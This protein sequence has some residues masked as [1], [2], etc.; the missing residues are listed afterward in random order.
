MN[1]NIHIYDTPE[2]LAEAFSQHLVNLAGQLDTF[3]I[4]LSGG[5]T[6]VYLFD[7]LVAHPE[8]ISWNK[9]KIFWVDERCVP[10]T[11]QE[12]NYRLASER[13]ISRLNIPEENIYRIHGE[14]DPYNEAIRYERLI[15]ETVP[16]V[17]QVPQ[18]DLI[19]LG[20][21]ADGHTASIFPE[22]IDLIESDRLC[23][24]AQH[25]VSRQLRVTFTMKLINHARHV[26]FLVTGEDKA[27]KVE[28]VLNQ[29][30]EAEFYPAN[31]VAPQSGS[32]HWFLDK[33]AAVE[34]KPKANIATIL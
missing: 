3:Y 5:K 29:K 13:L 25:P 31:F 22:Q 26:A 8:N 33:T 32:L 1:P 14:A 19:V 24:I 17:R 10:P 18:F 15:K 9:V 16:S 7:Y 23:T 20:M 21:G 6:P 2:Q 27:T 12:S 30:R 4:A 34:W 11:D 28:A